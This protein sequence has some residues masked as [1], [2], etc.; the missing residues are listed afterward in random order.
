MITD[1]NDILWWWDAAHG[2]RPMVGGDP[3]FTRAS[4]AM[5]VPDSAGM[6]RQVVADIPRF[7]FVDVGGERLPALHIEPA[8]T[9]LALRSEDASHSA[10]TKTNLTIDANAVIAPDGQVTA[11][12]LNETTANAEHKIRQAVTITADSDVCIA[13]FYKPKDRTD[14]LGVS[15]AAGSAGVCSVWFDCTGAGTVGT[16]SVTLTTVLVDTYIERLDNGWYLCAFICNHGSADTSAACEWRLGI[17]TEDDSYTGVVGSGG[18]VWGMVYGD[19]VVGITSYPGEAVGSTV[20]KSVEAMQWS[21]APDPQAMIVYLD[22]ISMDTFSDNSPNGRFWHFGLND[23]SDPSMYLANDAADRIQL[24]ADND[25]D[26][27]ISATVT[28]TSPSAGDRLQ[29]IASLEADGGGRLVV[30]HNGGTASGAD[31]TAP[32]A[33]LPS[34]WSDPTIK[35]NS[36]NGSQNVYHG[37]YRRLVMVKSGNI[38]AALDGSGTS[39]DELIAEMAEIDVTMDG[40]LRELF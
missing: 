11:D 33:G 6:V 28:L 13:I 35:L 9:S 18:W 2:L 7:G 29:I 24:F 19:D 25:V 21:G 34:V 38:D 15:D 26:A 32:A 4:S 3:T 37:K 31:L 39:D 5:V 22:V 30:S 1:I 10:W 14:V 23:D 16:T 27:G 20:S 17:A 36:R 8:T 40:R 12:F